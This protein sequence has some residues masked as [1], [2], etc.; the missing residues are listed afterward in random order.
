MTHKIK[1]GNIIIII[2]VLVEVELASSATGD[3]A[4]AGLAQVKGNARTQVYFSEQHINHIGV[5]HNHII[6]PAHHSNLIT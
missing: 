1:L 5:S 3:H 6:V 4:K 2:T